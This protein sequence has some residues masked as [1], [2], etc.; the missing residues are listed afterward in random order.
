MANSYFGGS[1]SKISFFLDHLLCQGYNSAFGAYDKSQEI[2]MEQGFQSS[3]LT[4]LINGVNA[5]ESKNI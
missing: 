1:R 5:L 2:L 3:S 4:F